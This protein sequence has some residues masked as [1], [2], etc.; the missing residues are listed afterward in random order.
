[1]FNVAS[2]PSALS[3]MCHLCCKYRL[4]LC[5]ILPMLYFGLDVLDVDRI[6]E[7]LLSQVEAL[8]QRGGL[9]NESGSA[10]LR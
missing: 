10:S 6:T 7:I 2:Q 1:M 9:V 4:Q 3:K 5:L 8:E